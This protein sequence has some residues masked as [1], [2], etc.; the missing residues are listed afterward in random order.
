[1][2]VTLSVTTIVSVW[3]GVGPDLVQ[4]SMYGSGLAVAVWLL[5]VCLRSVHQSRKP[6]LK[7][8]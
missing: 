3:W 4:T 5:V 1:M 2:G 6:S 7:L 8:E